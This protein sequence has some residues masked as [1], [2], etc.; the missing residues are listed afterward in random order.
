AALA[1]PET[2]VSGD[3]LKRE[4]VKEV[5]AV[6]EDRVLPGKERR[7]NAA[8]NLLELLSSV[9]VDV[10]GLERRGVLSDRDVRHDVRATGSIVS[11]DVA[12]GAHRQDL[13]GPAIGADVRVSLLHVEDIVLKTRRCSRRVARAGALRRGGLTLTIEDGGAIFE[14]IV[15]EIALEG[16]AHVS[17]GASLCQRVL[18]LS[19]RRRVEGQGAR[20]AV[21]HA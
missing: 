18:L 11:L 21:Q 19:K 7:R 1:K 5:A 2:L 9:V 12:P 15:E 16:K 13:L 14:A 3:R 17:A 10:V 6:N 8:D 20:G 4:R